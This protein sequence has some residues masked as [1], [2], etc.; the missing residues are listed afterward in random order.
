MFDVVIDVNY[1]DGD[2]IRVNCSSRSDSDRYLTSINVNNMKEDY[3]NATE[4]GLQ[5]DCSV[6]LYWTLLIPANFTFN[7][8]NPTFQCKIENILRDSTREATQEF[9]ILSRGIDLT[10]KSL[11]DS[12]MGL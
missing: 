9:T 7:S 6:D 10:T 11:E 12:S 1:T 4:S 2:W 5:N 8:T 3:F